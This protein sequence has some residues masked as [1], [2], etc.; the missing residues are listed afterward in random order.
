MRTLIELLPDHLK[1]V[2]EISEVVESIQ[3]E[4][5]LLFTERYRIIDN[6]F[7]E[8]A[9]EYGVLRLEEIYNL[10][11]NKGLEL[12]ERKFALRTLMLERRPTTLLFLK[13]Q[14]ALLCGEDGFEF[15]FDHE[16][17]HIIVYLEL[18]KSSELNAVYKL[19]SA[20]I[21]ACFSFEVDLL[22]NTHSMYEGNTYGEVS[23]IT[24]GDLREFIFD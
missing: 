13:T 24:H 10:T 15:I 21:P 22:Y 1:E 6:Q 17:Y 18:E 4:T 12:E 19:L 3:V 8:K 11:E 5:D 9:D 2:T 16:N 20:V 7:L 23:A 14:I